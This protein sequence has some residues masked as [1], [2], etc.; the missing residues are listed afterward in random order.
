MRVSALSALLLLPAAFAQ[1]A[2]VSGAYLTSVL[3]ALQ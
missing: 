3:G 2:T 1:N